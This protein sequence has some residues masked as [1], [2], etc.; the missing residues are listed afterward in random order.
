M[1]AVER[2]WFEGKWENGKA[3]CLARVNEGE[4]SGRKTVNQAA[5]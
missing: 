3:V 2:D 5:G 4:E 1:S